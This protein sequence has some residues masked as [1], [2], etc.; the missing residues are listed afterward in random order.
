MF[1]GGSDGW[2]EDGPTDVS[3]MKID[4]SVIV[5]TGASSGIGRATALALAD[6]G[7]NLVLA[8]RSQPDLDE[9]AHSCETSGVRALAV[10]TDVS[11]REEVE[12]LAQTAIDQFGGFDGWIN[13]AAVMAYG[14]F[15]EIPVEQYRQIL[16]T[17]LFGT[18]HGDRMAI[19]HYRQRGHGVLV[20]VSSVYGRV[21]T[22][23][24]SPY[25]VSKYAIRGLT[26]CLRQE[27]AK[28]SDIDV[29]AV[30]PQAVDT[31]IFRHAAN[32]TGREATALP[33]TADPDRA[34]RAVIRCLERPRAERIVGIFGHVV[35]WGSALLPRVYERVT[36]HVMEVLAFRPG[37]EAPSTGN[38]D[39]PQ[40]ER[41][42]VGGGWR[43]DRRWL[44]RA[45]AAVGVLVLAVAPVVGRRLALRLR[46]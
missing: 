43:E 31:P 26:K 15:W 38:V 40:P 7:A 2:P 19:D 17:N 42:A 28:W 36:P 14:S 41:N 33:L 8:A 4:G 25:V 12:K 32:F 6:R 11:R 1:G 18:I 34:T 3:G 21:V 44:R 24:V 30:S 5:L 20:N 45:S 16:E 27:T 10:P 9:V 46:G 13:A 23:F 35:A 39:A 29:C 22:P 37:S